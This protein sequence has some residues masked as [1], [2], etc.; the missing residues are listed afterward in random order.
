VVTVKAYPDRIRVVS[1]GQ[2][3][4]RHPRRYDGGQELD[5]RHYLVTL[6]RRP[7]ALDHSNVYRHW[8]LPAVFGRLR[9]HL[10]ERHRAS[11]GVRH[12][13]RV[14]QL[15][16]EHPLERVRRAIE[17]VGFDN[18]ADADRVRRRTERLAAAETTP[19]EDLDGVGNADHV[20]R[21][22]VPLPDLTKFDQLI[23]SGEPA[24]V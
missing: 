18:G 15:L 24:Y 9:E 21:V 16:A 19:P 2:V 3:V 5:P 12:Y 14:L 11:A 6:E 13:I 1:R 17:D 23:S 7:A 10:E 22:E 20:G 4:A 8:E